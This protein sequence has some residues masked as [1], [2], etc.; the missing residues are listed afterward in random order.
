M[1]DPVNCAKAKKLFRFRFARVTAYNRWI[2]STPENENKIHLKRNFAGQSTNMPSS[3]YF[4]GKRSFVF[5]NLWVETNMLLWFFLF[6]PLCR[7]K[8]YVPWL[9]LWTENYNIIGYRFFECKCQLLNVNRYF[10]FLFKR[11]VFWLKHYLIESV[12][13]KSIIVKTIL[14]QK[15]F[16]RI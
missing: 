15:R 16:S 4:K 8:I 5:W 14:E 13:F 6:F 9:S 11:C 7:F 12:F 3:S 1:S 2:K 10:L